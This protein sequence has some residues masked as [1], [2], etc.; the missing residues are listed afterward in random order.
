MYTYHNIPTTTSPHPPTM[1]SSRNQ[2]I[3]TITT[4]RTQSPNKS[5]CKAK[6]LLLRSIRPH[7]SS[8]QTQSLL[9]KT[10]LCP[11]TC[12]YCDIWKLALLVY[13]RHPQSTA[14]STPTTPDMPT[15]PHYFHSSHEHAHERTLKAIESSHTL[16]RARLNSIISICTVEGAEESEGLRVAHDRCLHAVLGL[17]RQERAVLREMQAWQSEKTDRERQV[18][19][20]HQQ[21]QQGQGEWEDCRRKSSCC[22]DVYEYGVGGEGARRRKESAGVV[23]CAM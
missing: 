18:R 20:W 19:E 16:Q 15:S 7:P 9:R 3:Y 10:D 14:P 23:S 1:P 4:S 21:Q 2:H 8:P 6:C 17:I 12:I 5:T 11:Q 22:S 13:A